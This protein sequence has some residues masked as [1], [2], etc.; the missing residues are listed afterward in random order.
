[1]TLEINSDSIATELSQSIAV[2]LSTSA[3]LSEQDLDTVAGGMSLDL[4]SASQFMQKDVMM[5]QQTVAGPNGAGTTNLFGSHDVASAAS[6]L[7]KGNQ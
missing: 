6:Q 3:E 2:E 7:F 1:M 5:G 4:G